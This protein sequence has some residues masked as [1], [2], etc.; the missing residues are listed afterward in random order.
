MF[1]YQNPIA[2]D[3][4]RD[5]QITKLGDTYF[6][7]GTSWPF[8][9]HLGQNPGVRLWSSPDLLN[10]KLEKVLLEPNPK[11]WYRQRFWAPEIH[12]INGRFWLTYNC[13]DT[14]PNAPQHIG[15]AVADDIRGPYTNLTPDRPLAAGNDA[16]L[17]QDTDGKTYL[18]RSGIDA[19]EIDL[20]SAKLVG[21]P[22]PVIATGA[23]GTWDG[24]TGVGIEGPFVIKQSETYTLFYSSWGRGYEVGYATA[25]SIRGPWT[26]AA[27]N[28]FYGAQ[29]KPYAERSGNLYTQAPDVPWREVRHGSPFIGPDGQWWLSSHGYR[30]DS[31]LEDA[32]LVI[33]P[34]NFENGLLRAKIPTWTPQSV[35][36]P[37]KT[38]AIEAAPPVRSAVKVLVP[39]ARNANAP[40]GLP[41]R[42][43]FDFPV[44][45]P[46]ITRGH[47][48]N[49]YL[50]GTT[51][52]E[53]K[54]SSMW[55]ENDGVRMWRS[56]DLVTWQQMGMVWTFD[57]DGTW[58][59][60]WKKSPWVSP[61]G[62]LR[63]A[64]WAPE[65]HYLKGTYYIPYS[66][67]Y[68]GTGI[69]KST[70]GHPEGPYVDVKKDGPLTDEID[71]SL[72]Q[73]DDGQVYLLWADY[74]I[75]RL[76]DDMSALA[77]APRKVVL[78]SY[79]WGEGINMVKLGKKYVFINSGISETVFGGNT[80][81][82]YDS[83]SATA[84]SIYGPYTARY[85]AIPHAGHN[86]LFQDQKGNW[87]ST[88]FG[89]GDP[90]APWEIKPGVLPVEISREGK[91][92]ARPT[93]QFPVWRFT[94]TA[95][96]A[97]WM[98]NTFQDKLWQSGAAGF[99]N[100]AILEA[101]S[102]TH[103]NTPWKSGDIWLR[104]SVEIQGAAKNP[105]L[106]LRH[107]G[108]AEVFINGQLVAQL[109]GETDNYITV[110]L[111]NP[112]ALRAGKN[113]IAVHVHDAASK[114]TL[115]YFDLGIID[116][117]M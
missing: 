91:V 11:S 8:F 71:T 9:E 95:P 99:G 79:P 29:S 36:I 64:L 75:A 32:R 45:D 66:M 88:Y 84:D 117:I 111:A 73:D 82:T 98:T 44:R 78:P 55:H 2:S 90:Y 35:I 60:A 61:N 65:I 81:K 107:S 4:I 70:S 47:D 105:Q 10:W 104:R 19:S 26:K 49:Y 97:A 74:K 27:N 18:F 93:A 103:V 33:D 7:T 94:T 22:F 51:E 115:A 116:K 114:E 83:Y 14:T 13:P 67:N 89:S 54:H 68:G 80:I 50:V 108:D 23:K 86:N 1:T 38:G 76:T 53:D 100:A 87:W 102:V 41:L 101:G 17:F 85:R 106:W 5:P 40:G 20:A 96:P 109:K 34:L 113:L 12:R 31:K 62:E 3:P 92:R 46:Y 6:M 39:A 15:L 56:R 42:M 69:L 48:G 58:S 24:G 110:P 16:T 72:F 43:L 59:K 77:E 37:A 63:R 30:G 52:P 28:P 21:E 57:K 112:A 25:P